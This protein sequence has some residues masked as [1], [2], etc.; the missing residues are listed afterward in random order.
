MKAVQSA[1]LAGN[2]S[3]NTI[4]GNDVTFTDKPPRMDPTANTGK[5]SECRFVRIMA[6]RASVWKLDMS[7]VPKYSPRCIGIIEREMNSIYV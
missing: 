5:L 2:A 6:K 1:A 7:I 3:T 4:A